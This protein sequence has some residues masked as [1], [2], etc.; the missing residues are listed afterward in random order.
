LIE[1]TQKQQEGHFDSVT[2]AGQVVEFPRPFVYA[3]KPAAAHANVGEASQ[4]S[5]LLCFYDIAGE[6]CLPGAADSYGAAATR[7]LAQSHLLMFVFD[8]LQDARFRYKALGSVND[9]EDEAKKMRRQETVLHE[10]VARIRRY[11]GLAQNSKHDRPLVIVVTKSDAWANLVDCDI[12]KEP[13]LKGKQHY[14]LNIT[15]VETVSLAI[16][17]LLLKYCPDIVR[18]A[19]DFAEP[20]YVPVSALG[21]QPTPCPSKKES[22]KTIA[23]IRPVDINPRWVTVPLMAGGRDSLSTLII[24]LRAKREADPPRARFSG[25]ARKER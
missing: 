18:V 3:L 22:G 6:H 2:F 8:P 23:A 1:K 5:R 13:W 15:H 16:R 24:R 12:M 4:I 9:D 19:E 25:H 17:A 21:S 10:A 14:G 7:H 20:L 11:T